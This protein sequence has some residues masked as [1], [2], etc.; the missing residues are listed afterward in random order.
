MI[1]HDDHGEPGT[2]SGNEAFCIFT[3]AA[4]T[5][6]TNAPPEVDSWLGNVPRIPMTPTGAGSVRQYGRAMLCG[7]VA[8]GN[9]QQRISGIL[10]DATFFTPV[11]GNENVRLNVVVFAGVSGGTGSGSVV[12]VS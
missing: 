7:T 1:G 9:L 12:D 3:P 11:A 2:L 8:Y 6:V 4:I 5:V 10:S